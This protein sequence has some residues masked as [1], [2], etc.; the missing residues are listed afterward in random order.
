MGVTDPLTVV[1]I[2]LGILI[3]A[4]FVASMTLLFSPLVRRE[5]LE[6]TAASPARCQAVLRAA[7]VDLAV[8]REGA[9]LRYE[10][11]YARGLIKTAQITTVW[12][13]GPP[14]IEFDNGERIDPSR[15]WYEA[16][17]CQ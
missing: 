4:G 13:D 2:M 3:G 17:P 1:Q 9:C 10:L 12:C 15:D 14:V 5:A 6:E 11:P 7:R 8:V 16:T